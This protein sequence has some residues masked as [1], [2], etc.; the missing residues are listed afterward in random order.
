[1]SQHRPQWR[2]SSR[3]GENGG[4]CIELGALASLIGVRDSK[5]PDASCLTLPRKSLENLTR[6]LKNAQEPRKP[7][8]D[9]QE[10]LRPKERPSPHRPVGRGAF[11]SSVDGRMRR[12]RT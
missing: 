5:A 2:K 7:H 9:P 6:I 8:P 3:S 1:M 10:P 12:R 4:D 11:F